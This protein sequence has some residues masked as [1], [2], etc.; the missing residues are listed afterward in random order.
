MKASN[1]T[2]IYDLRVLRL[3]CFFQAAFLLP[4]LSNLLSEPK[5]LVVD[6]YHCEPQ[7]IIVSPTRELAIQIYEEARKFAYSS[8]IK[9][10][11]VY[12]GTNTLNQAGR[13]K[14]NEVYI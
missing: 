12:G 3:T 13:V 1:Y 9:C 5:D 6:T 2:V 8:G 7:V 4:I 14:V 10:E 11:V